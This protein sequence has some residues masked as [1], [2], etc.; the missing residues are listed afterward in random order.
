V[1]DNRWARLVRFS[2]AAQAS[3]RA[4]EVEALRS[5]WE[6]HHERN[7]PLMP[8]R[9]PRGDV[10][11]H[12]PG[13]AHKKE[14][15]TR[16]FAH[17]VTVWLERL[18][19]QWQIGTILVFA[20]DHFLGPLRSSWSPPLH[21]IVSEHAADLTHFELQRLIDHPA[22]VPWLAASKHR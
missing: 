3:W 13:W 20:P 21:S 6:E 2:T 18:A 16:R 7:D 10:P 9:N 5:E 19:R 12:F 1:T 15:E 8:D 22:V 14:E 11:E 4:E 17:R